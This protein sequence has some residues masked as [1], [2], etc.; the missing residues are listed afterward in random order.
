[1]I[2]HRAVAIIIHDE[3]ILVIKR[4]KNNL[5][6]YIFPGGRVEEGE[7]N[8]VAAERE[9][10]EETSVRG[11]VIKLIYRTEV[12]DGTKISY[13]LCRYL[14]GEPALGDFNEKATEV[15]GVNTYDPMWLSITALPENLYPGRLKQL[16][17]DKYHSNFAGPL[18]IEK[19]TFGEIEG[20]SKAFR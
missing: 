11:K 8:E 18:V 19:A 3:N 15:E 16:I 14:S 17:L 20:A 9:L 6:Y 4:L 13:F 2:R 10:W 7:P 1:M 12:D 5:S